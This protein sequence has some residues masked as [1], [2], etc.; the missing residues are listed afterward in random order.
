MKSMKKF[1]ILFVAMAMVLGLVS[2]DKFFEGVND[3]P[4]DPTDVTPDVI[5][6]GAQGNLAY[7][8]GGDVSRFTSMLTQQATGATRQWTTYHR[9]TITETEFDNFWRFGMYGGALNDL[10]LLI[11]KA[12]SADDP[13]FQYAGI[14]KVLM[15]YG[16][17]INTDLFDDIP[18]SEAFLGTENLTPAYDSQESI[19]TAVIQ[20]LN[21][22]KADLDQAAAPIS[23]GGDDLIYGG[24]VDMWTMTANV[25]LARAYI[26]LGNVSATNYGNALTAL[27][28]EGTDSYGSNGD[29]AE[30]PFGTSP[31]EQAPWF[32]FNDQRGD[33]THEGYMYDLMV[34]IGDPR[35]TGYIDT[36][37]GGF[38]MGPAYGS[39]NSS[40]PFATYV[41]AK[42]IEAEAAFQTGNLARAADAHNAAVTA[43][44][45]KWG[46]SDPAYLAAEAS[47]TA[48]TITLEKIMTHKY[49]G[50]FTS[51]EAYNDWRRTGIPALS[52]V[53]GATMT[54]IPVRMPY[55]LSENNYNPNVPAGKTLVDNV[56][57]DQ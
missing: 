19:Y 40:W 39:P 53:T 32:Q 13:Y 11:E 38:L 45:D 56:W 23:P 6:A 3:N 44:L 51:P 42:F 8:V 24:D 33:I 30:F 12:E 21:D 54:T 2:C 35:L 52:P 1:S 22:G 29:D 17:M 50:M 55:P 27:G 46:I 5:L 16:L 49:I 26:H 20:L 37:G 34:S 31:T 18:Y 28:T 7:S 41:E 36:T 4:N 9:Y 14:A 43:G 48:G 10:Y 15:A 57:W 47:E 25:L